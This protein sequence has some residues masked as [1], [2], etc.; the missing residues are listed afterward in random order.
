MPHSQMNLR[1]VAVLLG[2]DERRA[3]RMAQRGQIPCQKVAGYFRFN[4]AEIT[5]WLQQN[6]P[7]L[8]RDHL[9]S[10]DAGITAHRQM[11]PQDTLIT[12]LV[13]PEAVSLHLPARTKNSVLRELVALA[14]ETGRGAKVHL[15][16]K[17]PLLVRGHNVAA[18]GP[19]GDLHRAA[20]TGQA[21]F[22]LLVVTDHRGVDISETV[23][24][25]AAQ[26][27]NIDIAAL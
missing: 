2:I 3:E 5:E 19:G 26:E 22:R 13:R 16:R 10:M 8:N 11:H 21:D 1:E 9:N 7:T 25:G 18:I 12:P 4:R 14:Q 20:R 27:T 15:F 6:M 17:P 23:D 24:L